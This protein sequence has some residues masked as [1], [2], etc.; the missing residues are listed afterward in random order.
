MFTS[1]TDFIE[2]VKTGQVKDFTLVETIESSQ[3]G[4]FPIGN[5]DTGKKGKISVTDDEVTVQVTLDTGHVIAIPTEADWV[6]SGHLVAVTSGITTSKYV[7]NR[8]F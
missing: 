8:L 1:T 2:A 3:H 5:A 4:T 6:F 7:M